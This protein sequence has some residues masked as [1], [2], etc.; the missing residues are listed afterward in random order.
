MAEWSESEGWSQ[1]QE[2]QQYF[3]TGGG[4]WGF[5]GDYYNG[6]DQT[7]LDM[8]AMLSTMFDIHGSNQVQAA[9][10]NSF[11]DPSDMLM[12]MPQETASAFNAPLNPS[13]GEPT[14]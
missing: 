5:E 12:P 1:S 11:L 3:G 4:A 13:G 9:E 10:I 8:D 2:E 7:A 6:F 14:L